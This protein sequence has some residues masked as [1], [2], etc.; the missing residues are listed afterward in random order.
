MTEHFLYDGNVWRL[1][2]PRHFVPLFIQMEHLCCKGRG[3]LTLSQ[4][5]MHN[6]TSL[7][8][9]GRVSFSAIHLV[10]SLLFSALPIREYKAVYFPAS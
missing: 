9:G 7:N 4:C 5:V 1:K 3:F 2:S 6:G 8:I 10:T